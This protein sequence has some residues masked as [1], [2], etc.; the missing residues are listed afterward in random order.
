MVTDY[1][2]KNHK[3]Q[4]AI[5]ILSQGSTSFYKVLN[6]SIERLSNISFSTHYNL[7]TNG[8]K[9]TFVIREQQSP[10]NEISSFH[11]A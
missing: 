11:F 7:F 3:R 10:Q 1:W 4:I 5:F 2:V 6:L 9:G 8:N